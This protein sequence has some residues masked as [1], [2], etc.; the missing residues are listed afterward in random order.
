MKK[1][2]TLCLLITLVVASN[3]CS[4]NAADSTEIVPA[5]QSTTIMDDAAV[6]TD[7][8][9]PNS[10]NISGVI[11]VEYDPEDLNSD[12]EDKDISYISLEGDAIIFEGSGATVIGTV[13]TITSA[14]TYSISGSLN[15][16][17]IIVDTQDAE[18]VVLV[19]NGMDITSA[20]S[21]PLYIRNAEKTVISLA[22][23][24]ENYVTDGAAY[25]FENAEIDEPNAAVFSKDDLTING[26]GSL[27]VT[28]NYNN[29][30][31]GKD[32]LKITGGNITVNA[33]NDGIKGWDSI[34]VKAGT[35]TV[36]AGGDGMQSKNAEDT[37]KGY[38]AIEN[39][40][41]NVIAG[42]DG[43]QAE[44][45]LNISAG[46]FTITSG[47]GST[48]AAGMS[49]AESANGIKAGVDLAITGGTFNIDSVDDALL[50]NNSLTIDNGNF[51]LKSGDDGIHSEYSL[52]INGGDVSVLQSF[53]GLESAVITINDGNVHLV[54]SDDGLNAT[55]GGGGGQVDGSYFYINGGYVLI[56]ASGDG[57]DSNGTAIMTGGVVIVQ[58]PAFQ[59]NG[60]LD[61]N[62]EF[63]ISGGF[64]IAAGSA[65][66]PETPST[67]STQNSIALVLDS[68][69][70]GGTI[71]HIERMDGEDILTYE[72]PKDFQL[73]VFSSPE[74]QGNTTYNIFT[75]GDSTGTV[76]D[77]LYSVGTYTSG[78]QVASVE[79]SSSVTTFGSFSNGPGGG[80]H[81]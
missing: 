57:L 21:A 30:I 68:T 43:I 53:E 78:T 34:A 35:I 47:G 23:G 9:Q 66:M 39:G 58:G 28:A 22:D 55:S 37:A 3:A 67:S 36:N 61:V 32:D 20:A 54:T 64:L 1:L 42:L 63:E 59:G 18:S 29:G 5:S 65:G 73:F 6:T 12:F 13:V 4:G 72:S 38:I 46:D 27:I 50:S 51:M 26:D 80:K 60:P 52:T 45:R 31:A 79:I 16:G 76:T 77:G 24:T 14:G 74:L 7:Q 15:D 10:E 44:T 33:V 2:I 48:N 69:M 19:L 75:G 11:S 17:Q 41:F 25:I 40:M 56:D 70:P 71:I 81:P 8:A 62:G 49:S